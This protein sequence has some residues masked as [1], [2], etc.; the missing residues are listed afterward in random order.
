MSSRFPVVLLGNT[1][2]DNPIIPAKITLLQQ[3]LGLNKNLWNFNKIRQFQVH[4]FLTFNFLTQ[5]LKISLNKRPAHRFD[6]IQI[7]YQVQ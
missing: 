4:N 2:L 1:A 5:F 3:I 6:S 7:D